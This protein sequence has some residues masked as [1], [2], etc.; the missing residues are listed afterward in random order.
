MTFE[1]YNKDTAAPLATVGASNIFKA[2]TRSDT[3]VS[4]RECV[5]STWE[6]LFQGLER[7]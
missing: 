5:G 7:D 4:G 2:K 6:E 1:C 3:F